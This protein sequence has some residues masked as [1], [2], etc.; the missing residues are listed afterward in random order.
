MF[1]GKRG[2]FLKLM[3]ETKIYMQFFRFRT[4]L[5]HLHNLAPSRW[6]PT[7]MPLFVIQ[8]TAL[9]KGPLTVL[10]QGVLRLHFGLGAKK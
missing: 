1:M 10:Y 7:R 6:P 9:L 2:C 4:F 5:G 3:T 8:N